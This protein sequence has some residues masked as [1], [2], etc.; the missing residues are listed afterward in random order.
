MDQET[1]PCP[2]PHGIPCT[3]PK[4]NKRRQTPLVPSS[5][6]THCTEVKEAGAAEIQQGQMTVSTSYTSSTAAQKA[7][8]LARHKRAAASSQTQQLHLTQVSAVP[9]QSQ[10]WRRHVTSA[11][12]D[13]IEDSIDSPNHCLPK[14]THKSKKVITLKLPRLKL[15]TIAC[16]SIL[17]TAKR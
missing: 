13:P 8:M 6:I 12:D 3:I 7:P 11:Q 10:S 16:Q 14:H 2:K 1:A 5:G 9:E 4:L 17:T 15:P